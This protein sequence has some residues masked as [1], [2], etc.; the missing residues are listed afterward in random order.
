MNTNYIKYHGMLPLGFT[1]MC[2][3]AGLYSGDSFRVS[4]FVLFFF[5]MF[6]L[7]LPFFLLTY[8]EYLV[9]VFI[10]SL[11][12]LLTLNFSSYLLPSV[13]CDEST[14]DPSSLSLY[15]L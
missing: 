5:S 13:S 12:L 15:M 6:V 2:M 4:M 9:Y 7:N 8:V 3:T 1:D 14:F 11:H 10:G